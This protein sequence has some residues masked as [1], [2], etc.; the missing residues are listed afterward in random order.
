MKPNQE[1]EQKEEQ[2]KTT[3]WKKLFLKKKRWIWISIL[4][5]GMIVISWALKADLHPEEKSMFADWEW[6]TEMRYKLWLAS[7]MVCDVVI[8]YSTMLAAVVIFYY[9]VTENKRL[10]IP[11]RRLIAY[12]VGPH[13]IP[14][15]FIVT[16]LLT[17][18]MVVSRHIPW[19]HTMYIS[20][21]YILLL[22]TCVIIEILRST[23][24]DYGKQVICREERKRYRMEIKPEE[25][26]SMNRIY[27]TGHLEQAIHSDEIILDKKELLE[28]FLRIPFQK[29]EGA[30]S[31]KN[32][33]REI[34]EGEGEQ[35]KIY[36]FYFSNISSA[37]QNL[38]G[39]EKWIER[40]EL[41]LCIGDF[42]RKLYYRLKEEADEK[43]ERAK[44]AETVYH[45]ALS[46]IINGVVYSGV[47][48]NHGFCNYIF[49]ECLPDPGLRVLQLRLY[50]LFREMMCMFGEK[51][52]T[53]RLRIGKLAEWE[54]VK[55]DSDILRCAHFWDIWV[56]PLHISMERKMRHFKRAMQTITGRCNESRAVLEMLLPLD[57]KR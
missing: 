24:Y 37:F 51:P 48:D 5:A 46:G 55:M 36:Q 41:Y 30:L 49:S 14:V 54:Y 22:Q 18:F 50:V 10:G 38:N 15:L 29:K 43:P 27:S 20:A 52:E 39:G 13:T 2:E 56:A 6:W 26:C 19:K 21:A 23:S 45:M 35:E 12:T 8:A 7:E 32:F 16:L 33:R 57:E 28:E 4:A 53:E 11:Y 9:S 17:V 40:S 34:F 3:V 42:L 25:S 44:E 31:L 1:K 47:E